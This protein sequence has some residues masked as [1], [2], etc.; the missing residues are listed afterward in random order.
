MDS[1]VPQGTV[2]GPLLFLIHINDIPTGI[3]S[4]LRLFADDCLLYKQIESPE[5]QLVMQRDLNMLEEWSLKWGMRFN[6][7]KCYIMRIARSRQPLTGM[8]QLCGHVLEEIADAKYLGVTISNDLRWE[9]HI[10]A[11]SQRASNTLS[12]LQRNLQCCPKKL[13]ETAYIALIHSVLEYAAVVWDPYLKKDINHL[14]SIQNR[15]ARFVCN[16]YSWESSVSAMKNELEWLNLAERR[17]EIRLTMLFKIVRGLV[18]IEVDDYLTK[19]DSRTRS[20]HDFKYKHIQTNSQQFK[21]S[22][23][24]RTVPDWNPLPVETVTAASPAS[25][26][27]ALMRQRR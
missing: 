12:F 20:S 1:G 22:F 17:R 13:K 5:D 11:I 6:A 27:E 24:P 15:S 19:A 18:E 8:Y 25:F 23:F 14:E 3:S 26:K 2:L 21:N 9:Q 7:R 10:L 4:N 16:N